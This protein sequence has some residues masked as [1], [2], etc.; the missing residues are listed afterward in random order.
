MGQSKP[1][2]YYLLSIGS[3]LFSVKIQAKC[4]WC[5]YVLLAGFFIFFIVASVLQYRKRKRIKRLKDK[6]LL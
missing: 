5:S 4:E 2:Q 1:L 6:G 3:L